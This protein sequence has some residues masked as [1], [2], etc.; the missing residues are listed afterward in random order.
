VGL[1]QSS[2]ASS[3]GNT[4][5]IHNMMLHCMKDLSSQNTS[6]TGIRIENG[7]DHHPLILESVR[8]ATR[9][10]AEDLSLNENSSSALNN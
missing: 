10:N 5:T 7:G 9:N 1:I 8:S 3:D 4:K 6:Q 2:N